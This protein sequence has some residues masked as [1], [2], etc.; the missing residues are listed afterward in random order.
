[1]VS[2]LRRK[3]LKRNYPVQTYGADERLHVGEFNTGLH[4]KLTKEVLL[5]KAEGAIK[6]SKERGI[7]LKVS[8]HPE[9][10][11]I[12]LLEFDLPITPEVRKRFK[13]IDEYEADTGKFAGHSVEVNRQSGI[14][15]LNLGNRG[16]VILSPRQSKEYLELVE[17][18]GVMKAKGKAEHSRVY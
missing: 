9:N 17:K 18:I 12:L 6:K 7:A 2:D 5:K 14:V 13:T 4:A 1:M 10:K 11:D 15:T 8:E 3:L 16:T